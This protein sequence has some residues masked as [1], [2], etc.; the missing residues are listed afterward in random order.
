MIA[1]RVGYLIHDM[2]ENMASPIE[3]RPGEISNTGSHFPFVVSLNSKETC[4]DASTKYLFQVSV[5][6]QK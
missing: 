5:F 4:T 1:W 3:S 2:V 6:F